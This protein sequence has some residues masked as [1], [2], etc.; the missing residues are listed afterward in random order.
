[1]AMGRK[2]LIYRNFPCSHVSSIVTIIWIELFHFSTSDGTTAEMRTQPENYSGSL[3]CDCKHRQITHLT[4]LG[5]EFTRYLFHTV[6][7]LVVV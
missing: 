6:A 2:N 4:D 1:M 7:R 3:V 5:D